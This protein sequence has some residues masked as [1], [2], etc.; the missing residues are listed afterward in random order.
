[1]TDWAWIADRAPAFISGSKDLVLAGA[2]ICTT[3]FAWKALTKWREETIGKRRLELAEDVLSIF[4]HVR[5]IIQDA[6]SPFVGANEMVREEGV[7]DEVIRSGY[8]A[9]VR[10][11]RQS[12]DKIADFRTKRHRF[13]A[14]FG[15]DATAPWNEVETILRDIGTASDMLLQLGGQHVPANDPSSSFY[16]GQRKILARGTDGDP[17]TPRLDAAVKAIETVCAPIIRSAGRI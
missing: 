16:V 3:F 7:P 17:I 15:V 9:P 8:Y 6:R 10:R 1:M 4:Y 12:F 13:A 5:E 2:A 14:V 11:L